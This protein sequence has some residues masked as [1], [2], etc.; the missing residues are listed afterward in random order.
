M[1]TRA[2]RAE[3][4]E[5]TP[6]ESTAFYLTGDKVA[7]LLGI[8]PWAMHLIISS[9]GAYRSPMQEP[10]GRGLDGYS[11]RKMDVVERNLCLQKDRSDT[12]RYCTVIQEEMPDS[13]VQ[14]FTG[15][16]LVTQIE[17]ETLSDWQ[18]GPLTLPSEE[19][20]GSI[21]FAYLEVSPF[22]VSS[23]STLSSPP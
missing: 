10:D 4:S 1:G 6:V 14:M 20:V 13:H 2:V 19:Q 23:G 8:D 22:V 5:S 3:A 18:A 12:V 11:W 9:G 17:R 7:V 15:N 16:N 21:V